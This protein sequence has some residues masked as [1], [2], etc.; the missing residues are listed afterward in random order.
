MDALP[1]IVL[2][3]ERKKQE[4]EDAKRRVFEEAERKKVEEEEVSPSLSLFAI[5][6][7]ISF[8]PL[9]GQAKRCVAE[10]EKRKQEEAKKL[11]EAAKKAMKKER[12][13]LRAINEGAGG[14]IVLVSC[15]E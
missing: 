9:I 1:I 8:C 3:R 4:K 15:R 2:I 14:S 6:G 7:S 13:R 5:F 11:R 12:Q 10:E